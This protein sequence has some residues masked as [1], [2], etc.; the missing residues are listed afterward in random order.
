MDRVGQIFYAEL[1]AISAD[2]LAI[3]PPTVSPATGAALATAGVT[4]LQSLRDQGRLQ[5]GQRVLIVGASGGVGALAV[6]V[7]TRLGAEVTGICSAGATALVTSLGAAHVRDRKA[8][9]VLGGD[10]RFH[11]IFDAAAAHS[12]FAIRHLL[13]PGGT[14]VSTLPGPGVFA[15]VALAPLEDGF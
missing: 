4:A 13:E 6:A 7:A 1:V 12:W 11:V 14:Y 3:R 10:T 5:A 15:A 8:A 9:D 2:A